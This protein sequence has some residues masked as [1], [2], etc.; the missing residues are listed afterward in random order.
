MAKQVH[1]HEAEPDTWAEMFDQMIAEMMT[2]PRLSDKQKAKL[3][4]ELEKPDSE[5]KPIKVK[6]KPVSETIIEMRGPRYRSASGIERTFPLNALRNSRC[7][8]RVE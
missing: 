8:P 5:R 6:G 1:K 2:D 3:L 4:A 7:D